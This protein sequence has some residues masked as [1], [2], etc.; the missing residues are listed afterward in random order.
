MLKF[1]LSIYF[2]MFLPVVSADDCVYDMS[3][4]HERLREIAS[5]H[6]E[7]HVSL[8]ESMVFWFERDGSQMTV[9]YGGCDHLG[10]S[11]RRTFPK[12]ITVTEELVLSVAKDLARSFWGKTEIAAL[13]GAIETRA[14]EKEETSESMF[15]NVSAADYMEFYVELRRTD[16]SIAISWVRNF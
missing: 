15:L 5:Q 9:I 8:D 1:F 4:Q 6:S 11:V 16:N 3:S 14:L 7:A 2:L 13:S 12:E 10:F